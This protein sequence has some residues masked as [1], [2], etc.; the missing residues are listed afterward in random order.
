[1]KKVLYTM[2][3]TLGRSFNSRQTSA[4]GR[5]VLFFSESSTAVYGEIEKHLY[6]RLHKMR[7]TRF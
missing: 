4:S 5:F 6:D 7:L 1:M 2:T 3:L